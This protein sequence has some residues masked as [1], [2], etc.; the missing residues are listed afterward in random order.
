MHSQRRGL[1]G[2]LDHSFNVKWKLNPE[3]LKVVDSMS[4]LP[5]KDVCTVNTVRVTNLSPWSPILAFASW[6]LWSPLTRTWTPRKYIH[7]NARCTFN[8]KVGVSASPTAPPGGNTDCGSP[9]DATL[10]ATPR[11]APELSPGWV[12]N[13]ELF[14]E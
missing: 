7:D 1:E 11:M 3:S 4:H 10:F 8:T 12:P 14:E 2:D 13:I 5:D 6:S 9:S